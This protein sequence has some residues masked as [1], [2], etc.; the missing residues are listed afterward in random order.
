MAIKTVYRCAKCGA[1]KFVEKPRSKFDKNPNLACV[2]CGHLTQRDK[3]I[4]VGRKTAISQ[5]HKAVDD[6]L[7]KFRK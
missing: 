2:A 4:D 5:F 6:A 3:I 7:R 1:D